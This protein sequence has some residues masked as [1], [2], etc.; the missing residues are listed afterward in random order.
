VLRLIR[1]VATTL[2]LYLGTHL[3]VFMVLPLALLV[4]YLDPQRIPALRQWFVG[5]LFAIVGKRLKVSG[6]DNVDPARRYVIVSNYPSGYAGFALLGQFPRASLVAHAWLR[7]I[8]LLSHA[9]RR[10]GAVFVQPGRAGLGRRAIDFY[11]GSAEVVPSLIILPEGGSTRDGTIRRFRRGFVHIQRQTSFGIL[12]VTLNGLYQ[13]KPMG[14]IYADPDADP[15]MIIHPPLSAP[16]ASQM[17]DEQIIDA[18][19][20][21]IS[22]GYRP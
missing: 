19:R 21:T 6:Q 16:V 15:Q 11:L 7:R 5:C 17:S 10:V 3:F 1:I 4:S 9:L 13:L 12:P 22:S 20:D 14:R 18:V 2:S 8:P